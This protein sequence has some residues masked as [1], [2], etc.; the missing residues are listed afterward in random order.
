MPQT[1]EMIA[2]A[3]IQ[4]A[5]TWGVFDLVGG[6]HDAVPRVRK[7]LA[8]QGR[9]TSGHWRGILPDDERVSL[10]QQGH[11]KC[12]VRDAHGD[13]GPVHQW[14]GNHQHLRA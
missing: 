1:P 13:L 9:A 10:E 2:S 12:L 7:L 6:A 3:A 11:G 5:S 14:V 8:E 4:E